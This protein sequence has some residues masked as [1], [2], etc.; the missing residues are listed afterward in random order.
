MS[1]EALDLS[2]IVDVPNTD[3]SIFASGDQVLAVW[4]NCTAKHFI[5]VTLKC[6]VKLL[7]SEEKFL[8]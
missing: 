3:Q 1:E 7:A 5:I 2:L 6:F 4:R 8:F